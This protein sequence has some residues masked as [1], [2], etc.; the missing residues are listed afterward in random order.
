M[1]VWACSATVY[2]SVV[3]EQD[4]CHHGSRTGNG[5]DSKRKYGQ[6]APGLGRSRFYLRIQSSEEH[7]Q[8]E[9]EKDD[10]ACNFERVQVNADG[11]ENEL[12][13]HHCDDKNDRGIGSS[14]QR[15][16]TPLRAGKRCRQPGKNCHVTDRVNRRPNSGE[17]F[18]NFDERRRHGESGNGLHQRLSESNPPRKKSSSMLTQRTLQRAWHPD[19]SWKLP[20]I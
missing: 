12:S 8:T 9:E 3:G 2:T 11:V 1:P 20:L 4:H 7:L 14:T 17:I 18:A 19:G 10:P 5:R 13:R 15:G 6:V 16:A